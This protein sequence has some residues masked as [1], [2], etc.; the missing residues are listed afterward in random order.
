MKPKKTLMVIFIGVFVVK[1]E[2]FILKTSDRA[3]GIQAL[4]GKFNLTAFSGRTVALKANYNSA[5]PFPASTH[6]DTLR[7]IVLA[8]KQADVAAITLAERSGM[9]KTGEVLD[10]MGVLDLSKELGFKVVVLDSV[11]K[12]EWAKIERAGTHWLKGFNIAKVFLDADKVVQT[13][14]LKTHRFGGHFTLS[15]KN[16][17]GLIAKRLPGSVYDYMWEL[18]GSPFQRQM[19]AEINNHYRV[20]AVLMDAI[21]AFTTGGPEDGTLVQPNL[22]LASTDS[23]AIDAVGVAILRMYG[24]EGKVAQGNIFDQDQLKRACELGFGAASAADVQLTPLNDE[25]REDVEKIEQ[26]LYA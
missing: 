16:S 26:V 17:V 23:V 24:V 8:L 18:H 7:A 3:A 12:D 15:L 11:G 5:D 6:I 14:C 4:L 1:S 10:K 19:I 25:S 13:C 21:Y 9:G 22:M 20:D 2:V